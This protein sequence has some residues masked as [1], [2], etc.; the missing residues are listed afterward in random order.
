MNEYTIIQS[1]LTN[2]PR[3]KNQSKKNKTGY[4]QHSTGTPG[5]K[6]SAFI[7]NWNSAS[8]QAEAEFIVDDT[9][10]YQ[11]L[12]IGVRAWHCGGTGNSTL[13]G[14]E[15]CEPQD[16]RYL[17][18]NWIELYKGSKN[19]PKYAVEALQ[20]A[21]TACGFDPNG[22]DGSFGEGCRR[23]V[24][25]FQKSRGLK[26]DGY[27]GL[28]T[29][30]ALQKSSSFLSYNLSKNQA[31]F[32]DVYNK[33]VFTCAYVLNRLQQSNVNKNTVL[34]HAEGHE[35]GIA[36]AHA[37]VR[38]WFPKHGKSMD[39]FR[40]DVKVYM[41]TGKLPFGNT[42]S[43]SWTKACEKGVFDGTNPNGYITREQIAIVLDRLNMLK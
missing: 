38:H 22:I 33:A 23:A 37:D 11:L 4:M 21:L 30:H 7:K 35:L 13:V 20:K 18:V 1:F 16:T 3:Y 36:S 27:V 14:C 32:E 25:E 10:I 41:S 2:N 40:E 15:V 17:D 39:N 6:A 5:A 29:L 34:S 19:N 12:P 9:G 8:A 43:D 42:L 24:V 31:Y 28:N 26:A